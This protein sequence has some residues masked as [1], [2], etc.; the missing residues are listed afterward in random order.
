MFLKGIGFKAIRDPEDSYLIRTDADMTVLY[1]LIR[2]TFFKRP[3]ENKV[4]KAIDEINDAEFADE[5]SGDSQ[6]IDPAKLKQIEE[7]MYNGLSDLDELTRQR[8][9]YLRVILSKPFQ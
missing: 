3:V 5:E 8:I 7:K 9:P 4:T 2:A 1:N 6:S